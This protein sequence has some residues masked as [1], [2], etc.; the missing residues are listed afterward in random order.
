[1]TCLVLGCSQPK[2]SIDK[3]EATIII[4]DE[5]EYG[6]KS[7]CG[8]AY[9]KGERCIVIIKCSCYPDIIEH[10]IRHCFE[11]NYHR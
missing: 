8:F 1:M 7:V 10:E 6:N 4:R 3:V 5:V 2:P 9:W 11:G